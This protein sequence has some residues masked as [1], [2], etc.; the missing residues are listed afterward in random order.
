MH[1]CLA[2]DGGRKIENYI[3]KLV[4]FF[5]SSSCMNALFS[6]ECMTWCFLLSALEK[7]QNYFVKHLMKF[8]GGKSWKLSV[9]HTTKHYKQRFCMLC[10]GLRRGRGRVTSSPFPH[11]LRN[12]NNK[13]SKRGIIVAGYSLRTS[14]ERFRSLVWW[15]KSF[16]LNWIRCVSTPPLEWRSQCTP[17][18]KNCSAGPV[19]VLYIHVIAVPLVLGQT[20]ENW[21]RKGSSTDFQ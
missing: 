7:N 3:A 18:L 12:N 15:N 19:Y 16:E 2:S 20:I 14:W 5:Q 17:H 10:Q 21:L 11:S 13:L 4:T 8:S 6:F 9:F 1:L